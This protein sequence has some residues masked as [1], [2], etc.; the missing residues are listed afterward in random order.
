MNCRK[1]ERQSTRGAK[2]T[3]SSLRCH[4]ILRK[5]HAVWENGG[6]VWLGR[7]GFVRRGEAAFTLDNAV[8]KH[9]HDGIPQSQT[10]A[11]KTD[12]GNGYKMSSKSYVEK[13]P[14]TAESIW[15]SFG[16]VL[17]IDIKVHGENV[18]EVGRVNFFEPKLTRHQVRNCSF[19]DT[20]LF[21]SAL[22]PLGTHSNPIAMI[23]PCHS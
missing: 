13:L 8:G 22:N 5:R 10:F 14:S 1:I 7:R 3:Q 6:T 18:G 12:H 4:S 19:F 16:D 17:F 11:L 9:F 23:L 2:T 15:N 21:L 20:L